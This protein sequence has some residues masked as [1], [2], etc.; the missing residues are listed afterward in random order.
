MNYYI[1]DLHLGH[2]NIMKHSKRPFSSVEE[3]D[4]TIIKNWN[5]VVND[6]DDVYI[7]GDVFYKGK[8]PLE[9]L[10]RLK[11]KKHLC[12]GNHDGR[13]LKDFN[14]RKCFVEI[15]DIMTIKDGDKTIVLCHYPMVEWNGFFRGALHFYGHIH[16]NTDNETYKRVYDI[17]NSYNIGI[18]ILGF[19]PRTL[20]EVIQLNKEFKKKN[21]IN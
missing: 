4:E 15:K 18:D 21:P 16:N 20:N 8:N 1:S 14:C 10:K 12:I 9:Y 17:Q 11:G 6:E 3:M 2:A 7:G 5:S 13:I 19:Y